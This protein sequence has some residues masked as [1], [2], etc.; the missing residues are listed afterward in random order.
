MDWFE[1][2][3]DAKFALGVLSKLP[4]GEYWY[5]DQNLSRFSAGWEAVQ[6]PV[7]AKEVRIAMTKNSY[8]AENLTSGALNGGIKEGGA[9]MVFV[10]TKTNGSDVAFATKTGKI[11]VNWFE[12]PEPSTDDEG[13]DGEG[14]GDVDNSG[15]EN[16]EDKTDGASTVTAFGAA[17]IAAISALVF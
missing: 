12:T 7:V 8:G 9:V 11:P 17:V 10:A 14:S 3:L 15:T 13:E 4:S 6:D 5:P 2:A 16:K 1:N